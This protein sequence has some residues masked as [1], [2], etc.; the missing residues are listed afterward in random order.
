VTVSN[1]WS[2]YDG[3]ALSFA[4]SGNTNSKVEFAN[5]FTNEF[6][7]GGLVKVKFTPESRPAVGGTFTLTSNANLTESDLAEKGGFIALAEDAAGTLYVEEGELVYKDR[8]YF[9]IRITDAGDAGLKIDTSW[10]TDNGISFDA[11]DYSSISDAL[12]TK[13]ANG[14]TTLMNYILDLDPADPADV[15]A[16]D[17]SSETQNGV[18]LGCTLN[19]NPSLASVGGSLNM[20]ASLLAS[21]DGKDYTAL[22]YEGSESKVVCTPG[23]SA[24]VSVEI[25]PDLA[26][27]EGGLRFFV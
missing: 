1:K 6:R 4:L 22:D 2:F 7:H 9:Y 20:T 8:G 12:A 25:K 10:L 18:S 26:C 5:S 14:Y 13:G 11:A 19:I 21:S 17:S 3:A 15:F 27:G 23:E 16:F 24:H